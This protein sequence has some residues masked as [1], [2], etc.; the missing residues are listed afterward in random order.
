MT[1]RGRAESARQGLEYM[2]MAKLS[3]MT[4][5]SHI[6]YSKNLLTALSRTF[7]KARC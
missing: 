7:R 2:Q 4:A 1:F 6:H 5:L 3:K